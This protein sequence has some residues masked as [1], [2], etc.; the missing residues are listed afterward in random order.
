[1]QE[2][3]RSIFRPD[4]LERYAAGAGQSVAPRLSPGRKLA[5]LWIVL[6]VLVVCGVVVGYLALTLLGNQ[7]SG[8]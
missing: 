1:V 6:G 7:S 2:T 4:A 5:Y 8:R 3:Q